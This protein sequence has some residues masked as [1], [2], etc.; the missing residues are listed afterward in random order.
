MARSG[1][2]AGVRILELDSIGPGPFAAMLL[3]DL[4]ANVLRISRPP[5]GG[6]GPNPVTDRGRAGAVALN[7]KDASDRARLM[8]LVERADVLIEGHRPGVMERLHLGPDDCFARNVRL[9]YGRVTGWGRNGPLA[10]AA[11]HDI[12]YIALTGALYACGTK[13]SGPIPPL[14]LVGDFGGGG[15]ML[16]FG[17]ACALA[18]SRVSGKGQVVDAAMLDGAAALMGMLYG[19]Q[20]VGR[21]PAARAG[22]ILDGSAYFYT[23]YRC[24]DGEWIAVGAVEVEF[25]RLFLKKLGLGESEIEQILASA[26]DD[27]G[28]RQR[29]AALFEQ[30]SQSYWRDVFEGSDAC[31]SPVLPMH[32]VLEH[33]QNQA[34][35]SFQKV[36]DVIH[37]QPAP[38]FSRTPAP[39]V[40]EQQNREMLAEWGI[41]SD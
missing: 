30:Q 7:L 41:A 28:A 36:G 11:G 24:A 13:Q 12:N 25:R 15:L 14:N 34:W 35:G 22:N 20:A 39:L 9:I 18:E 29:I 3:A 27:V 17:V 10:L 23:C 38:R 19:L 2:L 8:D 4:G 5:P 32:Q 31:V 16:A 1:P 21:W 37:P 26:D 6:R 40:V 33:A